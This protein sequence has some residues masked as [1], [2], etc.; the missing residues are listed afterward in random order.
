[1]STDILLIDDDKMTHKFIGSQLEDNFNLIHAY[2]GSQG[3]VEAKQNKIA[4]ILLD[5]EMP[6]E[7]GYQ[8]CVKL[9]QDSETKDIPIIFLSGKNKV[10]E[11]IKGYEAGADDYI[12]KPF[13]MSF[14]QTKLWVINNYY[15]EKQL[16]SEQI[17]QAESTA[18]TA[19]TGNS[20]LGQVISFVEKSYGV[21]SVEELAEQFL[22]LTRNWGLNCLIYC[23]LSQKEYYFSSKGIVKPLEKKLMQTARTDKRFV[24]FGARTIINYPKVSLLIKN[25]PLDNDEVYGRLKDLFPSPLGAMDAKLHA[26]EVERALNDQAERLTLTF[27][28]MKTRLVNLTAQLN[29]NQQQGYQKMREMFYELEARIPTLGLD[30]D[31]EKYIL[32]SVMNTI[33]QVTESVISSDDTNKTLASVLVTMQHLVDEQAQIVE[34]VKQ[35]EN[36]YFESEEVFSE[37][38]I[39]LF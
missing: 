23:E 22:T 39:E 10:E 4:L 6:G 30:D 5:I 8:V 29:E 25:M 31:Q 27:H 16:L 34:H 28:E 2:N 7:N 21:S 26:L 33:E 15:S 9:K 18:F 35:N 24:D 38:D 14:L 37:N 32:D 20:E 11:I 13:D 17:K 19:M 1:M 36:R 3:I 12:V